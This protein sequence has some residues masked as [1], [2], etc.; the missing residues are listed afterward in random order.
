MGAVKR[1][2]LGQTLGTKLEPVR[3][4]R[5]LEE[6]KSP[7]NSGV[8]MGEAVCTPGLSRLPFSNAESDLGLVMNTIGV[9]W[10]L[11]LGSHRVA[12]LPQLHRYMLASRIEA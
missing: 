11:S 6:G 5:T 4:D 1:P 8:V 7:S 2:A 9:S 3:L 10:S 12:D